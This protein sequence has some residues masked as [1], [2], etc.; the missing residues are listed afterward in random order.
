MVPNLDN[1]RQSAGRD[2]LV[3]LTKPLPAF[4]ALLLL[5]GCATQSRPG[6]AEALP[7]Q[8]VRMKGVA[9]WRSLGGRKWEDVK[10]VTRLPPG[11]V[12]ETGEDSRVDIRLGAATASFEASD[13]M[14]SRVD[15]QMSNSASLMHHN[16]PGRAEPR[17]SPSNL[18]NPL[19][20]RENMIRLR[21][22][23][24]VRFDRLTRRPA[25]AGKGA[26]EA[27]RL[28][29]FAGRIFGAV[30]K[31]AEGSSYEIQFG[32]CIARIRGTEYEV[33]AEGVV[34]VLVGSMVVTWSD[35]PR[36]QIIMGLQEFDVRTGVLRAISDADKRSSSR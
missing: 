17:S 10:A 27:V 28:Q 13:E 14:P 8:V 30:P 11:A 20:P 5:V 1:T 2:L 12:V 18:I 9:R 21:E 22:N 36:S 25:A 34:K 32:P 24:R 3:R 4:A 35:P 29:L 16:D 26:A 6:E 7:V 33:A 19:K 15:V 31:L 23:S